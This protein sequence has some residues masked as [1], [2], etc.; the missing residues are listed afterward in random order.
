MY[1]LLL[2]WA[3][4]LTPST[5]E[6]F[7]SLAWTLLYYYFF[8]SSKPF[9]S[10]LSLAST[11]Q[12]CFLLSS[13]QTPLNHHSQYPKT[14]SSLPSLVIILTKKEEERNNAYFLLHQQ[15]QFMFVFSDSQL[16]S[17]IGPPSLFC[18]LVLSFSRPKLDMVYR[19]SI[20]QGYIRDIDV[21]IIL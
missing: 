17:N 4:S 21:V 13:K 1:V 16:S 19:R 15:H 8:L 18:V 7:I 11:S 12:F 14:L 6:A 9:Q 5:K 10:R 2:L 20:L 3:L